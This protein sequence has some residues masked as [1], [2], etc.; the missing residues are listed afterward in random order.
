MK[1]TKEE[2]RYTSHYYSEYKTRLFHCYPGPDF[3]WDEEKRTYQETSEKY[4]KDQWNWQRIN[5]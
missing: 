3:I 5:D 2:M 4:P 1:N